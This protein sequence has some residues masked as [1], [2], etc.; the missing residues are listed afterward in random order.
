METMQAERTNPEG[1]DR[2]RFLR[3]AAAAAA[4][5]ASGPFLLRRTARAAGRVIV[6]NPGGAYG[7]AMKKAH[8]DPFSKA[9]GV[10]V[11]PVAASAGKVLAMVESGNVELDVLD[12]PELTALILRQKGALE[13]IDYKAFQ[14][15][16]PEDVADAR[17]PDMVGC[18]YSANVMAYNTQVYP[19]GKHPKSWAEFWDT[20]TF[21]GP[22]M[23]QSLDA[24]FPELEFALLADGVPKDKLY[25]I[26]IERA[27]KSLDR[28]RP[29]ISKFYDTGGI[30]VE[31]LVRKEAVLG[32][33]YNGRI[34]VGI[35]AGAPVA[36]EWNQA[37]V[38]LQVYGII[39]GA[40]NR[41]NARRFIDFAL[42][43]DRQAEFA[44]HIPY[45]PTNRG[46][47]RLIPA[48]V[49]KRLPNNY[50]HQTF[51]QNPAW[52]AENRPRVA[53]RWNQWLLQRG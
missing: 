53:E 40:P 14:L 49:A 25:P 41:D 45:G 31:M 7:E 16:N 12:V 51:F 29:S 35:D 9:T 43:P 39:K 13:P 20:K 10:E 15:T 46:S 19:T 38:Q 30:Q 4:A 3:H 37:N 47:F 36:I 17:R 28:V 23:L 44:R 24:G 32:S 26:D 5:V 22:R 2:R 11:V 33:A 34:Q 6:R 1:L 8:Y 48:E 50:A 52:W 27:F 18:N 21:P 42:Q